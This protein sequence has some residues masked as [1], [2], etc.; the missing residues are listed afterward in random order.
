MISRSCRN[1]EAGRD[2]VRQAIDERRH[3]GRLSVTVAGTSDATDRIAVFV[4]S[5]NILFNGRGAY[6]D[7]IGGNAVIKVTGGTITLIGKTASTDLFG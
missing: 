1:S 2:R 3:S 5:Q 7:V 4:G 6:A